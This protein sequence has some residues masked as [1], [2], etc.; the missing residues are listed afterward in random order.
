MLLHGT[1]TFYCVT[2]ELSVENFEYSKVL[3]GWSIFN[4]NTG[5]IK[6]GS[7]FKMIRLWEF[8]HYLGMR[9]NIIVYVACCCYHFF[10]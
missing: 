10:L 8:A 6:M 3:P 2:A 7:A 9:G 1:Y 4:K 5:S